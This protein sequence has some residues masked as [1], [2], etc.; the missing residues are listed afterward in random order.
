MTGVLQ[1]ALDDKVNGLGQMNLTVTPDA[2]LLLATLVDG[3]GRVGLNM[4]EQTAIRAGACVCVTVCADVL[5][6]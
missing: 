1:R 4:L 6:C 5:M 3:D 2:L